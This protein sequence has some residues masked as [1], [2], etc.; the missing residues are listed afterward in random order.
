MRL[1]IRLL[2]VSAALAATAAPSAEAAKLGAYVDPW[3]V[4]D[5][6]A[7]VGAAPQ[8]VGR[9]EAFSR[10]TTV[11]EFLRES[12]RQGLRRVLV[13]WEPWRPVPADRGVGE[14]FR[15]QPG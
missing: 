9:F 2:A 1:S 8:F 10:G 12:E 13:T 6:T 11:D 15:E 4:A 5:W 3:H 7:K 14:G